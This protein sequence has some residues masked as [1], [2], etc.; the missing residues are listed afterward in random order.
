RGP[1]D[2]RLLAP[3]AQRG[4][5]AGLQAGVE[6]PDRGGAGGDAGRLRGP[7]GR[8]SDVIP[9]G[10]EL[11]RTRRGGTS[12]RYRPSA[13]LTPTVGRTGTSGSTATPPP[14]RAPAAPRRG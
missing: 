8:Q 1:V 2:L 12:V 9:E 11:G 14:P 10:A 7:S 4:R 5:L 3:G 13:V 6:R